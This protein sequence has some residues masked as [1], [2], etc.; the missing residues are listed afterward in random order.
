MKISLHTDLSF[1]KYRACHRYSSA[2]RKTNESRKAVQYG[3]VDQDVSG[4]I[5]ILTR[6][7][8]QPDHHRQAFPRVAHT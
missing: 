6:D 2:G 1:I 5:L 4:R 8:P 3:W 7:V